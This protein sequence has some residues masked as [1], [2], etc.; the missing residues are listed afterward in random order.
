MASVEKSVMNNGDIRLHLAKILGPSNVE[1]TDGSD[2]Q[3]ILT[4][5]NIYTVVDFHRGLVTGKV[6][7][8]RDWHSYGFSGYCGS[9]QTEGVSEMILHYHDLLFVI[10][11]EKR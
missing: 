9:S 1:P 7:E 6:T 2:H 11:T 10:E 5:G 4:V 8:K 3:E